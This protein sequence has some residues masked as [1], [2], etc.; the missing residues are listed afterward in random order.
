MTN[1]YNFFCQC[2]E[3]SPNLVTLQI[4]KIVFPKSMI[5]SFPIWLFFTVS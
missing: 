4:G 5:P 2:G 1:I 3:I